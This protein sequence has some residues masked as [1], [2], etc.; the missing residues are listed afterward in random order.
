LALGLP[1]LSE[2]RLHDVLLASREALLNAVTHGCAGQTEQAATFRIDCCKQSRTLRVQ[3]SDSGPGHHFDVEGHERVA[4]HEPVA[5]HR[6]LILINH[7]ADRVSC[8]RE[9]ATITMEFNTA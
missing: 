2:A 6:A 7:L 4:A 3:V 8:E 9:G 5:E 1:D